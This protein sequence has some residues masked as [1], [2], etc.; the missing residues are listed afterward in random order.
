VNAA[1]VISS[2]R[3]LLAVCAHP[4]DESFGLGAVIST[5]VDRGATVDLV[6]LTRGEASTLGASAVDLADARG[7]ELMAAAAELGIGEVHLFDHPDG[8]LSTVALADLAADIQPLAAG[9]DLLLVFDEGGITGHPDH[10]HATSSAMAVADRLDLP[11]VAWTLDHRVAKRLNEEFDARF[12]GRRDRDIDL[13]LPVDRSRQRAA[14]RC[15]QSQLDDN[16]V[17]ARRIALTGDA[18]ALRFLRRAH[19]PTHDTEDATR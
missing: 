9:R 8:H 7:H 3:S 15:H 13:R 10:I 19:P 4:D 12:V 5:L 6:S 1:E 17:P 14:M 11:V 16:P 18:E 2:A